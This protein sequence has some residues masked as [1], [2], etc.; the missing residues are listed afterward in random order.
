MVTTKEL[1][2]LIVKFRMADGIV[3]T[4]VSDGE[5]TAVSIGMV[6]GGTYKRLGT[7]G[8][9]WLPPVQAA[10]RMREVLANGN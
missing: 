6:P 9:G 10:E 7:P 8:A 2:Q 3:R 1:E 4:K 5:I